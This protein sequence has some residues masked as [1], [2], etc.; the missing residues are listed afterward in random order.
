PQ[1]EYRNMSF[2]ARRLASA[3]G[4]YFLQES[5]RAVVRISKNQNKTSVATDQDLASVDVGSSADV[6]PEVLRHNLPSKI[7]HGSSEIPAS[8]SFGASM[9]TLKPDSQSNGSAVAPV[10]VLNP[11]RGYVSL[12]PVTFGPKRWKVPNSENTPVASTAND[13]RQDKYAPN[14]T[15]KLK[16][17]AA[18]L[19]RIGSAFAIAT[20]LIF[21]GFALMSSLLASKF[22]VHNMRDIRYKGKELLR[23][24]VDTFRDQLNPLRSWVENVSGKWRYGSG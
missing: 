5:K 2:L 17:A 21:G 13:L 23:P 10:N 20:A 16:A 9:W 3:E 1:Y 6:L 7:F 12:P 19:S 24:K 22:E 14:D 8:S 18:G 4:S 15:E 11:L